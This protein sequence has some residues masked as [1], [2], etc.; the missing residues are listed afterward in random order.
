MLLDATGSRLDMESSIASE[1]H[2]V[3]YLTAFRLVSFGP[4]PASL[5]QAVHVDDATVF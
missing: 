3:M 5:H 4:Y 2:R 1:H